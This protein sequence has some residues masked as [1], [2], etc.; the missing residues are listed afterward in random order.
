MGSDGAAIGFLATVSPEGRPHLAPVCPIF[1]G[2]E[3]YLSVG[4]ATPKRRDLAS[5]GAYVLH[6]F[7]GESDEE[8]QLAGAA[9][10]VHDAAERAAVHEA[11]PFAS[12]QRDDPIFRLG[13]ERC[14]WCWWEN[15]GQPDT[16]RVVRRWRA[17]QPGGESL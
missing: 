17:D 6:A 15:A 8:L 9:L 11:I 1:C 12:F 10:E 16:R 14:L 7:L 3:L 4:A 5:G 13:V 2:D